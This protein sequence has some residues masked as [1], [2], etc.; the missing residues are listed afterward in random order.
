MIVFPLCSTIFP[1][2]W[3]SVS[4]DTI[5]SLHSDASKARNFPRPPCSLLDGV[6]ELTEVVSATVIKLEIS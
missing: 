5:E 1:Y 2:E 6:L 4:R 3:Q